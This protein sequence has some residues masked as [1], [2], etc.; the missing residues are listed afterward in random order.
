MNEVSENWRTPRESGDGSPQGLLD[1]VRVLDMTGDEGVYGARL[2]A[3][4]GADVVRIHIVDGSTPVAPRPG[5]VLNNLE[6]PVS[7]FDTF[8]NLNKR[9]VTVDRDDAEAT[10]VV[11]AL[12]NVSDVVLADRLPSGVM[13]PEAVAL[14]STSSFGHLGE[15]DWTGSDLVDLAAG[16]LLSLGGYPD[17]PPVAVYGHQAY[18]CG[19]IMTAVAATLALLARDVVDV[20]V[21]ADLSVQATLVGALEDATA[22]YDLRASVRQRAGD[23]PREAGTGIFRSA[24]GFIAIVAGKLGTAQAWLNLIAWLIEEGVEGADIMSEPE[25]STIAKRRAPESLDYFRRVFETYTTTRTSAWLYREGQ[26]R[27]IAVAP[28]NTVREVLDDPQ[29]Q[30]RNF[31]REVELPGGELA[32]VPGRPYRLEGMI[33]NESWEPA[34]TETLEAIAAQWAAVASEAR[35]G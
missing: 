1:G 2:L 7:G 13:V 33:S 6:G 31:F 34:R 17:T 23:L 35:P 5:P 9:I 27:A 25:W 11:Q 32:T 26:A 4:L 16:G 30:H 19:G 21:R 15:G 24:D 29:L 28:V 22:E 3:D 10:S 12:V 18:L 20:P 8:V 14:V